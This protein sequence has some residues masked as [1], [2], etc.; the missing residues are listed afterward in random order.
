M[1]A[2]EG[3][4]RSGQRPGYVLLTTARNEGALI[5]ATMDAVAR[6][7]VLP[8]RWVI[9]SDGSTDNTDAVVQ[10][11]ARSLPFVEF[12][13]R[14]AG[15][16]RSFA[17]KARALLL[18]Y[19]RVRGLPFDFVGNL[20]ADITFTPDYYE[21]V[22]DAFAADP[23]LGLTGGFVYEEQFG[24]FVPDGR[25]SVRSVS[26]GVQM[27]RRACYEAV[28]GYPDLIY[29]GVDWAV[30]I[31]SRMNGWQVRSLPELR[32]DH[33]KPMSSWE[34]RTLR[35]RL[36][37]GRMD[38][39]MGS[40]PV[41]EVIKCARRVAEVPWLAGACVRLAGFARGW[42]ARDTGGV[43]PAVRAYVWREQSDRLKALVGIKRSGCAS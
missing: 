42:A 21:R 23:K 32:F 25:N 17:A 27:F 7:T 29:G 38:Y 12:I 28:G 4:L 30:E 11:R 43:P 6:Q 9:V 2:D 8:V 15:G 40:H 20:D 24:R 10:D 22:L 36:R 26:G 5:G 13:R 41:F 1:S 3:Q 16:P 35:R 39:A 19:D 31:L 14:D 37:E 18:A 33:H 34:W